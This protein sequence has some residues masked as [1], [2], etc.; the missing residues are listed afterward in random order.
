M[1]IDI[2]VSAVSLGCTSLSAAATCYN[3]VHRQ[4]LYA[5]LLASTALGCLVMSQHAALAKVAGYDETPLIAAVSLATSAMLAGAASALAGGPSL[6]IN[7]KNL[8]A[9]GGALVGGTAALT[10]NPDLLAVTQRYDENTSC[11]AL[12]L[13]GAALLSVY[14]RQFTMAAL[15]VATTVLLVVLNLSWYGGDAFIRTLTSITNVVMFLL[16]IGA[17]PRSDV[18]VGARA[19][20]P[21]A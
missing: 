5:S 10:A 12:I 8:L 15:T 9:L 19:T 2:L 21:T 6:K 14:R 1:S 3:A 13:L 18:T 4:T 20:A 16:A 7:I 17:Q 11:I